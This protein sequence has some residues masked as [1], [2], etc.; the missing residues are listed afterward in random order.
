MLR[1]P[2]SSYIFTAGSE[3]EPGKYMV[4]PGFNTDFKYK[5]QVFHAQTEDNGVGN[6]VIVTLLYLKGAILHSK[7]TSYQD[8]VDTPGFPDNLMELMKDQHRGIMKD[9]LS[10]R[11]DENQPPAT[12]ESSPPQEAAA[13]PDPGPPDLAE[14]AAEPKSLDEVIMEYLD[15]YKSNV[16]SD[17]RDSRR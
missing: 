17:L 12:G 9:V 10:G 15:S 3:V 1:R 6:P 11:F 5:G 7:K 2:G 8:L 14:A 13:S 4:L 16:A